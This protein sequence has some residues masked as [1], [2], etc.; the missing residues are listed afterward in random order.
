MALTNLDP[1]ILDKLFLAKM[2][3]YVHSAEEKFGRMRAQQIFVTQDGMG[4]CQDVADKVAEISTA[5]REELQQAASDAGIPA[6]AANIQTAAANIQTPDAPDV[7]TKPSVTKT[8]YSKTGDAPG[9]WSNPANCADDDRLPHVEREILR[10]F[11]EAHEDAARWSYEMYK[12]NGW[13]TQERAKRP[14][15]SRGLR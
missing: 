12:E 2:V 13:L 4:P 5:H 10:I 7:N 11:R 15:C 3:E 14:Q 1:K 6:P 9:G 8:A